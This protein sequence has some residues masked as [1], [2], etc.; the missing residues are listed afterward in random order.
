MCS[1]YQSSPNSQ[2]NC[3]CVGGGAAGQLY[4][5]LMS[6]RIFTLIMNK[7]FILSSEN[8]EEIGYGL[9]LDLLTIL[10]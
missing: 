7:L 6:T 5:H 4:N 9:D 3:V 1:N 10:Y 8:Y 2:H